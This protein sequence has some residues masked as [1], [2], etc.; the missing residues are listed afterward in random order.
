MTKNVGQ[1]LSDRPKYYSSV[2][3]L[4]RNI[5]WRVL[6]AN[7]RKDCRDFTAIAEIYI[8]GWIDFN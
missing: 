2:S 4:K 3:K 6:K 5:F 1:G 7:Q 8:Y